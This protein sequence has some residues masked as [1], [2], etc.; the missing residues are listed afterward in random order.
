MQAELLNVHVLH[1]WKTSLIPS[2]FPC[3]ELGHSFP[4]VGPKLLNLVFLLTLALLYMLLNY[5]FISNGQ[6]P[7]RLCTFQWC[8]RKWGKRIQQADN[9]KGEK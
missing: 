2:V 7:L 8:P 1:P 3:P 5:N 4:E 9:V 6:N